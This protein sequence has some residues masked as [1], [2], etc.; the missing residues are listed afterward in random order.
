MLLRIFGFNLFV[1]RITRK[2]FYFISNISNHL[3]LFQ[4]IYILLKNLR[5]IV[6]ILCKNKVNYYYC[7]ISIIR[8]YFRHL[9]IMKI[10]SLITLGFYFGFQISFIVDGLLSSPYFIL[11]LTSFQISLYIF[12]IILHLQPKNTSIQFYHHNFLHMHSFQKY[13]VE[14]FNFIFVE[15]T[16][17]V[18]RVFLARRNA[19]RY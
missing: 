14:W 18:F 11:M 2:S 16:N 19:V 6:F 3:F 10:C 8:A 9:L 17:E 15:V 12:L 7:G 13:Y 1:I 4:F 5:I